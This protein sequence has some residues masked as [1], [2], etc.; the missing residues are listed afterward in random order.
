MKKKYPISF[1]LALW[2]SVSLKSSSQLPRSYYA[3]KPVMI[4]S[5][6][7]GCEIYFVRKRDCSGIFVSCCLISF[8]TGQRRY[9]EKEFSE[10]KNLDFFPVIKNHIEINGRRYEI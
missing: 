5:F 4:G 2:R 9:L 1:D 3:F 10:F 7:S 6:V 8:S